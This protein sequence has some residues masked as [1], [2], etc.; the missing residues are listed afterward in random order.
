MVDV[1]LGYVIHAPEKDDYLM[2]QK[3]HRGVVSRAWVKVPQ[4]A[5]RYNTQQAAESTRRM[6]DVGYKTEVWE[7]WETPDNFVTCPAT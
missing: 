7:L 2:I 5:K 4:L 6:L 1:L 3:D